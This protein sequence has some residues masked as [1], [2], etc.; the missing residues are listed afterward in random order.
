MND[1][2]SF[3]SSLISTIGSVV[4]VLILVQLAERADWETMGILEMLF[5]FSVYPIIGLVLI[6]LWTALTMN[7]FNKT[8]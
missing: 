4:L 1:V 7:L 6:V 3:S 5:K 8:K 2:R